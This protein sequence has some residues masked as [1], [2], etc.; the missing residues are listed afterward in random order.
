[1][2]N[3]ATAYDYDGG[4]ASSN[5]ESVF[6]Y[7]FKTKES[8]NI[9]GHLEGAAIKPSNFAISENGKTIFWQ[10]DDAKLHS[11]I[12]PRGVDSVVQGAPTRL[13]KTSSKLK[14]ADFS[15]SLISGDGNQKITDAKLYNLNLSPLGTKLSFAAPM[16]AKMGFVLVPPEHPLN[17]A[18]YADGGYDKTTA[19]LPMYARI[20]PGGMFQGISVGQMFDNKALAIFFNCGNSNDFPATPT[21]RPTDQFRNMSDGKGAGRVIS[22]TWSAPYIWD[23]KTW[24]LPD[25]S[26]RLS[27]TR[28]AYDAT[29]AKDD[30]MMAFIYK[31]GEPRQLKSNGYAEEDNQEYGPLEIRDFNASK[32]GKP[33]IYEVDIKIANYKGLAWKP[34]GDLTFRMAD[35]VYAISKQQ[36][37]QAVFNS[38]ITIAPK[39]SEYSVANQ[40]VTNTVFQVKPEEIAK[41][42]TGTRLCWISDTAFIIRGNDGVLYLR[43]TQGNIEPKVLL[44]KVPEIFF[45][46]KFDSSPEKLVKVTKPVIDVD[47]NKVYKQII[48]G[49]GQIPNRDSAIVTSRSAPAVVEVGKARLGWTPAGKDRID[50]VIFPLNNSV[51]LRACAPG[52]KEIDDIEDPNKYEYQSVLANKSIILK[53]DFIII[54]R[55]GSTYSAIKI[56]TFDK[57]WLDYQWK[58]WS[59]D[60]PKKPVVGKE[61]LA[62]ATSFKK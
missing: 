10:T 60:A 9:T 27:Y 44:A 12:F 18:W 29:W 7:D 30:Q 39:C 31:L 1:M 13:Y 24:S 56:G 21:Y 33:G 53:K 14:L 38:S 28:H 61:T 47:S 32:N 4:V 25:C 62:K 35:K 34:N 50:L 16:Q 42:V 55:A 2:A 52:V 11:C 8:K 26:M 41:N 15:S 58:T 20:Q 36:I 46:C 19:N 54:I 48:S 17:K 49:T 51:S 59:K 43:E 45:Y 5:G 6:Y 40:I 57:E 37:N 3:T 22:E 23:S